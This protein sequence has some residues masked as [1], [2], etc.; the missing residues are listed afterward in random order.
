ML[1]YSVEIIVFNGTFVVNTGAFIDAL[2]IYSIF[3]TGSGI[4]ILLITSL[5]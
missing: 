4:E 2:C 3:S 1:S 5:I